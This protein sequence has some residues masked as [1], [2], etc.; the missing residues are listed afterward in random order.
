MISIC[1]Y[2]CTYVCLLLIV[3]CASFCL[4]SMSQYI[5]ASYLRYILFNK[6]T[7]H[8]LWNPSE[9]I[10]EFYSCETKTRVVIA[11]L[12]IHRCSELIKDP[13]C[14]F[15]VPNE[16]RNRMPNSLFCW[17]AKTT[18]HEN[19]WNTEWISLLLHFVVHSYCVYEHVYSEGFL[20]AHIS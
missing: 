7:D 11:R 20:P 1:L 16:A 5:Y 18:C 17:L 10:N 3:S 9:E 4:A 8:S 6:G 2:E 15:C 13:N 12:H 19:L 14:S